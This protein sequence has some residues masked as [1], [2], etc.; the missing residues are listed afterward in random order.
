MFEFIPL[1]EEDLPFLVKV[2]NEC[3]DCL[4][5]NRS[6]TLE[7]SQKWF[8]E[9]KPDFHIIRFCGERIGYFRL[10]N[11]DA[12]AASI[13]VGADLHQN[14]RGRGLGRQAYEAF[15]PRLKSRYNVQTAM[16]EVLS[17]NTVAHQFYQKLGFVEIDRKKALVVRNGAPVDSIVMEKKL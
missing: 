7:E 14:F 8:R 15:L 2:R 4:H 10:G 13:Y 1:A 16:L 5:D 11:Y 9:N 3:R 6:F 12:R 17:H